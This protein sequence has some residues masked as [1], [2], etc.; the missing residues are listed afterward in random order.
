MGASDDEEEYVVWGTPLQDEQ[1]T[2]RGQY[3]KAVQEPGL[4]KAL[5]VHKQVTE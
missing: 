4:T 5:P 3:K 2:V 1:E